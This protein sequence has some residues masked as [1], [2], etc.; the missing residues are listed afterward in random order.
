MSIT[1]ILPRLSGNGAHRIHDENGR[2]KAAV[3]KLTRWQEQANDYFARLVADRDDVYACWQDERDGRLVAES[4]ASQ[5][6]SERDEWRDEALALRAELAPYKAA[7]ANA[8]RVDVPPMV[9][10]VDG[11]EDEATAPI[12]VRP[13]WEAL[14]AP[15]AECPTPVPAGTTYCSARCR[16]AADSHDDLDGDL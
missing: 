6:R 4:A 8:N 10:P 11:P 15:C 3:R 9:R 2:L 13:L 5:M 1:S 16:N 12:D 7:E 14:T